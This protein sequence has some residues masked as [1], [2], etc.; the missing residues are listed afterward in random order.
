MPL[1]NGVGIYIAHLSGGLYTAGGCGRS[2]SCLD[3]YHK[4]SKPLAE[5]PRSVAEFT[6]ISRGI[7]DLG[8]DPIAEI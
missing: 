7:F 5:R 4:L 3:F 1:R 6:D 2:A 8:E